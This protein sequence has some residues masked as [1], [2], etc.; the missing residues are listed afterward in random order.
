MNKS[1]VNLFYSYRLKF[2]GLLCIAWGIVSFYMKHYRSA[3]W[4]FN[5]LSALFS[6]GLCFIFFAKEKHD[7]ERIHHLKFRALTFSLPVGLFITHLVNYIFLSQVEPDSGKFVESISAYKM[8][9][10]VMV[11]ALATFYYFKHKEERV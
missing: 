11:V 3:I 6:W 10:I 9:A 7:D 5:L 2:V 1:I 8:F 4:D